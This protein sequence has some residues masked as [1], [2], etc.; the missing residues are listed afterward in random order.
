[1]L[2]TKINIITHLLILLGALNWAF[3][4]AFNFSW[5]ASVGSWI[6]PWMRKVVYLIVGAAAL[7]QLARRDYYLNFLGPAAFPCGSLIEKV[8]VNADTSASVQVAPSTSVIYWAAEA[9]DSIAANPWAAYSQ[10]TNAG[11]ARSD[12][13]GVAILKVRS[14]VGYNVPSGRTLKPHVHYRTCK[15][16]G[17]LGRVQT[18]FV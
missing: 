14:P 5:M 16:N 8:P 13:T 9:Q 12:E 2:E 6:A 11:V 7:Y 3:I 17:M 15:S 4:G 18:V 10:Y 1:M